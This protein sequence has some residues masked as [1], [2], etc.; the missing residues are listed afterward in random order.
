LHLYEVQP[1]EPLKDKGYTHLV[2][3]SA[4]HLAR[5]V[6]DL[7][8]YIRVAVMEGGEPFTYRLLWLLDNP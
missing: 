1:S 7:P 6:Y 4:F 2:Y 8:V 3:A 5:N